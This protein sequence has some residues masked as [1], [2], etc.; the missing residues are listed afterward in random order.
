[1][2]C[3]LI[4]IIFKKYLAVQI[5]TFWVIPPASEDCSGFR[6]DRIEVAPSLFDDTLSSSEAEIKS[7]LKIIL[8]HLI[9]FNFIK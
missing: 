9:I 8:K 2:F 1:M 6:L 3:S 7:K 4:Q 5:N